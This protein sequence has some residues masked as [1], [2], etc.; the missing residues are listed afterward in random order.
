MKQE[1]NENI[2][3]DKENSNLAGGTNEQKE[4]TKKGH[5]NEH[6]HKI[7][8]NLLEINQKWGFKAGIKK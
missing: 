2:G 5:K 7:Y 8:N 1:K 4:S 3:E 6:L